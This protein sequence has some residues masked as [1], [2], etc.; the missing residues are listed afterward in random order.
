M[1]VSL[2]GQVADYANLARAFRVCSRGK[3]RNKDYQKMLLDLGHELVRIREKLLTQNY[4]WSDYRKFL[5]RDPKARIVSAPSFRDRVVHT[6]I[7]AI[8]EPLIDVEIPQQVYACRRGKGSRNAAIDL[9]CTLRQIGVERFVV[10]LDVK[11]YF[12]SIDHEILLNLVSKSL[13]DQSL[14]LLLHGLVESYHSS[15]ASGKGIPIGALTSQLF[16][17]F[18]LVSADKVVLDEL[19]GQGFY[20][21]YMDDF[22]IGGKDRGRIWDAADAC[23]KHCQSALKLDIP[24]QKIVPL[25]ADPV[26]FLG[27]LIDHLGYRPLARNG[28]RLT[29]K[30][31]RMDKKQARDSTKEQV[32]LSYDAWKNLEPHLASLL[33]IQQDK[34]LGSMP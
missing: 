14:A 7:C 1:S 3:K 31:K 32:M 5:V 13:P 25:G 9:I 6:A 4:A 11:K 8:I 29:K 27:F 34:V 30:L 28:R 18:Y 23:T 21:R 12:D 26:P 17:N 33:A 10:K 15:G 20:F 22:V 24:Y 2:L 16:A 19:H